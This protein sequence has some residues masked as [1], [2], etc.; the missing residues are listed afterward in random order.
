MIDQLNHLYDSKNL[1]QTVDIDYNYYNQD[2]KQVLEN[3]QDKLSVSPSLSSINQ[4]TI[5][6]KINIDTNQHNFIN[7]SDSKT[8]VSI[9]ESDEYIPSISSI[10]NK[11]ES[12]KNGL[13]GLYNLGNTCYINSIIQ[14]LSH[15][16]KFKNYVTNNVYRDDLITNIK[17]QITNSNPN[18]KDNIDLISKLIET[19]IIY[20]LDRIFTSLWQEYG[21][22]YRIVT[23]CKLLGLIRHKYRFNQQHDTH[24][25]LIDI[26][27]IIESETKI[28]VDID[29]TNYINPILLKKIEMCEEIITSNENEDTTSLSGLANA[30]IFQSFNE[31]IIKKYRTLKYLKNLYQ[32]K[33]S[34]IDSLFTIGNITTTECSIC[35]HKSYSYMHSYWI[36][37]DIPAEKS[38]ENLQKLKEYIAKQLSTCNNTD[39]SFKD[40]GSEDIDSDDENSDNDISLGDL[41]DTDN[42]VKPTNIDTNENNEISNDSDLD[43]DFLNKEISLKECFDHTFKN[44]ILDDDNKWLCTNCNK[45]NKATRTQSIMNLSNYLIVQIKRFTPFGTKNNRVINIPDELDLKDYI[46]TASLTSSCT[47][48]LKSINNHIGVLNFGHYYSYIRLENDIWYEFNDNNVRELNDYKSNHAYL[49]IYEKL[50]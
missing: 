12:L 7:I 19:K 13:S 22:T 49:V 24:E 46:D 10:E 18:L 6:E 25:F 21:N 23:F 32:N 4:I 16:S 28:Q 27:D 36:S 29:I 26:F 45:K 30:R 44:E 43:L 42:E 11:V 3:E 41:S 39:S 48:K 40:S 33:Y 47:Y 35:N 50:S 14:C 15:L 17:D 9:K 1:V 8:L 34:I 20:Q 31:D 2:H 37:I 38:D 5:T